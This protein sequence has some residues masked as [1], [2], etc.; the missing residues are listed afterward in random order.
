M[1][2]MCYGGGT[3]SSAILVELLRLG[4]APDVITFA[5]TGAERSHTY[6]H[7]EAMSKWCIDNGFPAITTVTQVK[8]NGDPNYLY[9][10]CI[11]KKMLPSIAYGFKSCSQKHK[12]AP[13]DKF[14]NN[15]ELCKATWKAGKK[16]KKIIGYD[17]GEGHRIKNY[18]DAKYEFWYPLVEWGWMREDC[19]NALDAA[20]ITRP[21]KSS[22]FFCPS[23]KERE[24]KELHKEEPELIA[25]AIFMEDNADLTTIKGLGRN[26]SWKSVIEYHEKQGDMF[27]FS[28]AISCDCY[29]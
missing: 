27:G 20:G 17:A 29:E 15:N 5:D 23:M 26:W 10:L 8:E 14:M 3:N 1:L 7:I 24:I 9:E 4:I 19:V 2:A 18:D 12:I 21:N 6:A 16:V 11:E 13:Q 28:P 22:C 25:K